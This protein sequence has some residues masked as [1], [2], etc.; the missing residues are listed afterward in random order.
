MRVYFKCLACKH[1]NQLNTDAGTRVEFEMKNP[2]RK[3]KCVNCSRHTRLSANKLY[4]KQS[5]LISMISGIVF[6][7]GTLI[8]LYF[9]VQMIYKMETVVGIYIIASG[10]LIPVSIYNILNKEDQKRVKIFN[11]TYVKE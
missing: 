1:E 9:V 3:Y 5:K 4:T 11:Q 7:V 8:A 10:L 2:K 6:L